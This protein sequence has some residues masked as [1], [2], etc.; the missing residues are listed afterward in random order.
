MNSNPDKGI[1]LYDCAWLGEGH[2]IYRKISVKNE[3]D[4]ELYGTEHIS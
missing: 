2:G 3:E 1:K 4:G